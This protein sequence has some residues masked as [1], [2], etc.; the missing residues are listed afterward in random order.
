MAY[1]IDVLGTAVYG[2]HTDS[3]VVAKF[4]N[5]INEDNMSRAITKDSTSK[6][7]YIFIPDSSSTTGAGLTGL[8]YNSAAFTCYYV[9]NKAATVSVTLATQTVTGAYSS[10]GFVEV[11][12]TNAPGIYRF[13]PPNA[14]LAT[15][16]DDV[17]FHFKG[18]TNMAPTPVLIELVDPFV[19]GSDGKVMLSTDSMTEAY[20]VD[21]Q[22][23]VSTPAALYAILQV[24]TEFSRSGTTITV[25]KR[26]GT[27]T[28][29][30]LTLDSSTTP[31]SATQAS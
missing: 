28:A 3:S 10:G 24:L 6:T 1:G 19:L 9:R 21:G 14:A 5:F 2:A 15:G 16:V 31:T 4:R 20:P 23:G 22:A 29:F 11:D 25:K 8:V 7:I 26:D 18:A 30:T 13:D 12:A 17:T 27:T